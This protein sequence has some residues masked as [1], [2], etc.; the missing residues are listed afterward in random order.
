MTEIGK[1]YVQIVPSMQGFGDTVKTAITGE[2]GR[3]GDSG[4]KQFGESFR[5]SAMTGMEKVKSVVSNTLAAAAKVGVAA[6]GAASTAVVGLTKTA[7]K[8]YGEYEQLVGGAQKIFD[9]MDYKKIAADAQDA[10]RTMNLS[11]SEYLS[12]MNS[13]GAT[14]SQT[15]GDEKG[16]ET[17]KRGMQAIADYASGTGKDVANLNDKFAL[18]TR[19]ASSYQSIADQFSGI[20][21]ALSKDFLSQAQAAGYLSKSYTDLTK[22]PVAE[23]Q[24]AVSKMLEK[25]VEDL[26]LT[27]NTVKES[28]QTLTGSIAAMKAS[29]QNLITGLA[30]PNADLGSLIGTF[31]H[32]GVIALRNLTPAIKQTM[33]GISQ[34]VKEAAPIIAAELPGL[35]T[36]LLPSLLNAAASMVSAVIENLPGIMKAI[37]DA[38]PEIMEQIFASIESIL[39][40]SLIPAFENL[41]NTINGVISYL[42]NLDSSQIQTIATIAGVVA[43]VL[44][45]IS[46]IST[47]MSAISTL[48]AAITFLT[49]PI[50]LVVAAVTAAIAIG[51]TVAKHWDEIKAKFLQGGAE[52][53]ADWENMKQTWSNLCQTVIQFVQNLA[54]SVRTGFDN[55]R[56]AVSTAMDNVRSTISNVVSQALS[57]GRDLMN[58]FISGIKEKLGALGQIASAAASKV[59]GVLHFSEPDEGPL[60]N[61]HTFAPDMM[62]LFAQGIRQNTGLVEK[63]LVNL[64]QITADEMSGGFL[65]NGYG[66]QN[67]E[68]GATPARAGS[69][70][71]Q[72]VSNVNVKFE[73]ALAPLAMILKPM[74]ETETQRLGDSYAP[75]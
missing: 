33:Q 42:T 52:L 72:I 22:V 71:V 39:P 6:I 18:I 2:T 70:T 46:T 17:A 27:N 25:G 75:A 34:I 23:Y 66:N 54:S 5:S 58:N 51:V 14:F 60:K 7:V 63:E 68:S 20:L 57:W 59:A 67:P 55:V 13:V 29:W 21:P 65:L 35:I 10:Y 50:G 31:V 24:E 61:F 37:G 15:M 40:E 36:D 38:I 8:Q 19:S 3:A 12:M 44:G 56:N 49:S 28:E 53:K 74:I 9:Q 41:K 4:G 45:V 1:A 30:D 47:V 16:Y 64:A 48:S 11:A 73:G 32:R 62:R 43:A 26:G 69:S